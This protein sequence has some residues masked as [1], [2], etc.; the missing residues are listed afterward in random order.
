MAVSTQWE[1]CHSVGAAWW[2]SHCTKVKCERKR[3]Q[4]FWW[5]SEQRNM[6]QQ[7]CGRHVKTETAIPCYKF[8]KSLT[9]ATA[10][11]C[12]HRHTHM[13]IHTLLCFCQVGTFP[14]QL[15]QL[16]AQYYTHTHTEWER[17]REEAVSD[18]Q[19]SKA[20][21]CVSVT[22]GLDQKLNCSL[23]LFSLSLFLS[24]VLP[25]SFLSVSYSLCFK[26][27]WRRGGSGMAEYFNL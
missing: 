13:N 11:C 2:F 15:A 20:H 26:E 17:E 8:N 22:A 10:A 24:R 18:L 5:L 6:Q 16:S 12:S 3:S 21:K 9:E 19:V 14:R 7:Q 23:Q 27:T 1:V 25:L 4:V